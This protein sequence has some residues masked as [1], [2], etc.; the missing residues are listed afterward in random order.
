MLSTHSSV[1]RHLGFYLFAVN[2][3]T[4]NICV[5]IFEYPFCVLKDMYP[6]MKLLGLFFFFFLV[7]LP[8][9]CAAP[10]AHGGSQARG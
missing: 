6:K 8:F 9:S 4:M 5:E 3:A 2:S 7:F 1:D 10:A